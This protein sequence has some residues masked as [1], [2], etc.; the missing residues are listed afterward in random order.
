MYKSDVC[1]WVAFINESN[2]YESDV[3]IMLAFIN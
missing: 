3:K 1:N 2:I